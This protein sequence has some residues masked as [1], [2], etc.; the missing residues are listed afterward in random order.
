MTIVGWLLF[1]GLTGWIASK[2][3]GTDAQQ[4]VVLNILVGIVGAVIGGFLWGV[5]AY[6]TEPYRFWDIGSWIT[7]VL[8]ASIF[9]FLAGLISGRKSRI[10]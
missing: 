6:D 1:G 8:G 9:L 7:A 5:V 2:I 4:G 3:M 10:A